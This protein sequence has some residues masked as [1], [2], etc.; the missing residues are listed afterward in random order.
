M[1]IVGLSAGA[2]R[3]GRHRGSEWIH[4]DGNHVIENAADITVRLSD[5]RKFAARVLGRDPE[6][7]LALPAARVGSDRLRVGQWGIAIG[8]PFN[9][10][11]VLERP[12][13]P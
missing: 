6:A 5:A 2:L 7:D 13:A 1:L 11:I 3:L 9:A 4:L 10:F 12:A 8:N